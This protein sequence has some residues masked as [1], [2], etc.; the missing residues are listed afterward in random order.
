MRREGLRTAA[1]ARER[2]GWELPELDELAARRRPRRGRCADWR[3]G[4][5]RRRIAARAP[6]LTRRGGAR[7]P[8]AAR[9]S[10]APSTSSREHRPPTR[11]PAPALGGAAG[12]ARASCRCPRRRPATGPTRCCSPSRWRS[13]RGAFARCSCA[14]CRRASSRGRP[15][16]SRSCPTSAASS[17]PPR[18]ACGCAPARTRCAAER[19][20]FYAALSRATERVFL[21]YRSSDEEG[22]LALPSPFIADVAELLCA[23]WPAPAPPA[24]A[25]RRR[26]GRRAGPHRARARPRGGRPRR[27]GRR[28]AARAPARARRRGAGPDAP[29]RDPVGGRARGLRRLPGPLADRARAPAASRSTPTRSR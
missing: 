27:G 24:P 28:R 6:A 5:S 21:A 20:L 25:R 16:P 2:L 12:A 29:H 18:A 22:N 15:A 1:Q 17:W 23:D 4:C 8:G 3:G 9:R 26:L 19:Y 11:P 13:A 14:A 10:W 7:R